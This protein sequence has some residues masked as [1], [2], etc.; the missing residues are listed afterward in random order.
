MG[1]PSQA[2]YNSLTTHHIT[3]IR[4]YANMR[5]QNQEEDAW[6]TRLSSRYA[7][8]DPET[9]SLGKPPTTPAQI[10][11]AKAHVAHTSLAQIA[12]SVKKTIK[13]TVILWQWLNTFVDRCR[14]TFARLNKKIRYPL[15]ACAAICIVITL[16]HH[17]FFVGSL[18]KP[19]PTAT[20]S[21][22]S[23]QTSKNYTKPISAKPVFAGILPSG[24]T[25]EQLG[26]WYLISPP[27]REPAYAFADMIGNIQIDIS[28]Q[29]LPK[30]FQNDTAEQIAQL[31]SS[32]GANEKL[33]T[34]ENTIYIGT[35]A[36]GPQSIIFTRNGLLVL[37]KSSETLTN[38]QWID[39]VNNLR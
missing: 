20:G 10:H 26:G 34:S 22:A 11:I 6:T 9:S 1:A 18:T 27:N 4:G 37:I 31:A 36:K 12:S 17:S 5:S 39:Y 7:I 38:N 3:H 35:S 32:F 30:S 29:K 16:C 24:K 2:A 13:N 28:Q 15:I 19:T 25:I 14:V 21:S 33:T 8:H 23:P